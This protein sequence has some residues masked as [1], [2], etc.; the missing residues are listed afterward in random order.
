MPLETLA[1]LSGGSPV[2]CEAS[3]RQAGCSAEVTPRGLVRESYPK[4]SGYIRIYK[5]DCPDIFVLNKFVPNFLA[6]RVF[7]QLVQ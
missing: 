3:T 5:M 4:H 6:A 7:N 1:T 2:L